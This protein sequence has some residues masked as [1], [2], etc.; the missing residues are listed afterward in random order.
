M[1]AQ[2]HGTEDQMHPIKEH[3]HFMFQ[4][5]RVLGDPELNMFS[6]DQTKQRSEQSNPEGTFELCSD[7]LHRLFPTY[8]LDD[9][10]HFMPGPDTETVNFA[11]LKDLLLSKDM[12]RYALL[13]QMTRDGKCVF[14]DG[15][16]DLH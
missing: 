4:D 14:L 12:G 10:C 5:D 3:C 9:V 7:R 15:S 8:L 2:G 1:I 16:V 6:L 13:E 11:N